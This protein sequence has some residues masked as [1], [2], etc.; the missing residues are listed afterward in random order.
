[1]HAEKALLQFSVTQTM[2]SILHNR[3]RWSGI[4]V[5]YCVSKKVVGINDWSLWLSLCVF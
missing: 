4:G 1:L 2:T 3:K 5:F